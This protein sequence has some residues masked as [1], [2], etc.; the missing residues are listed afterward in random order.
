MRVTTLFVAVMLLAFPL[1]AE[2]PA[3]TLKLSREE[4]ALLDLTNKERAKA[5][6]PALKANAKLFEAARGHAANMAKQK[7]MEHELDGKNVAERVL[8]TGYEYKLVGENI[9]YGHKLPA[10]AITSWMNSEGHRENLL[11]ETFTEIGL[12][13]ALDAD[14]RPYYAQVFATPR[15]VPATERPNRP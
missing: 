2:E 12:G 4:Q 5:K 15:S 10:G 14:R 3:A 11:R 9:A 8:A 7:K 6:L 13:I 1:G